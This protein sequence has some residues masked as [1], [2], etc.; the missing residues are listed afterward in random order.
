MPTDF[1][2]RCEILSKLWQD[3]R[4][5]EEFEDF[6]QYNDLGLPLAYSIDQSIVKSS[7]QAEIF[8]N[9]TYDLFLAALEADPDAEYDSLEDLLMRYGN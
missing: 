3:F 6:I 5:E 9:E 2:K 8:I 7:P 1:S 4:N